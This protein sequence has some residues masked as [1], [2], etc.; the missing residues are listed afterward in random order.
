MGPEQQHHPGQLG[1]LLAGHHQGHLLVPR[2]Q[3]LQRL[4]GGRRRGLA[5]D[6]VVAPE[7]PLQVAGQRLHH[8]GSV[9]DQEQDRVA[10]AHDGRT[11]GPGAAH[12]SPAVAG[13]S[14]QK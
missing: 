5:Q 1:H 2:R 14:T 3:P 12:R 6:A 13:L 7:P 4:Q 8:L 9:V 11:L 10:H